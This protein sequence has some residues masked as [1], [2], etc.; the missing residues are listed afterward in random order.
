MKRKITSAILI[1]VGLGF[2]WQT[3]AQLPEG[4]CEKLCNQQYSECIAQI[5][6]GPDRPNPKLA[7]RACA[8]LYRFCRGN[9]VTN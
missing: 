8:A 2:L 4:P 1:S 9:C 3:L 6:H 7:E 5:P